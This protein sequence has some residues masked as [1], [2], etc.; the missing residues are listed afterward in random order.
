[1]Q[2]QWAVTRDSNRLSIYFISQKWFFYLVLLYFTVKSISKNH[3]FF[4]CIPSSKIWLFR[5][6]LITLWKIELE[7][8]I[9]PQIIGIFL[10]YSSVTLTLKFCYQSIFK[11]LK[12]NFCFFAFFTKFLVTHILNKYTI[13]YK[14]KFHVEVT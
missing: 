12:T 3:E 10:R 14:I 8:Q 13:I 11:L 1:M 4:P 2:L 7:W 9:M 5:K 6:K